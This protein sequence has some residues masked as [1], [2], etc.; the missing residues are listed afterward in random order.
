MAADTHQQHTGRGTGSTGGL[1]AGTLLR[2]PQGQL[3]VLTVQAARCS[4]VD[5][6]KASV[7]LASAEPKVYK[8]PLPLVCSLIKHVEGAGL[9]SNVGLNI[10]P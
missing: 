1:Q 5:I 4:R 7:A 8:Y 6:L 10:K 2:P 9:A 3:A